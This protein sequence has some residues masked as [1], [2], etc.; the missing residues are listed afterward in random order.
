MKYPKFLSKLVFSFLIL[1]FLQTTVWAE[2][3]WVEVRSRNFHLIG[4]ASEKDIRAV[5]FKLEQFREALRLVLNQYNFNSPV[6]TTVVVFKNAEDYKPYKP[7][8]SNGAPDNFVVG[9]FQA[10]E[11]INYITL[12]TEGDPSRLYN[13]IFHEYTHF[14]LRNNLGESRIPPWYNEGMAEYYETF[15]IEDDRKVMIGAVHKDFLK[16]LSKNNLIPF[17]TFFNTD[18]Y[19]LHEQGNDG[20]GLF[21]AQ[22]WALMHY[23]KHGKDSAR[24]A[25]LDKFLKLV[26]ADKNPK[27]AFI[28]AFQ[29]DYEAMENE[30]KEYIRQ[31]SFQTTAV[32]FINKLNF[33]SEMKSSVLTDA[34]TQAYLGDLLFHSGRIAE[35]EAHLQKALKLEPELGMAQTSLGLVKLQQEDFDEAEKYLEKAIRADSGNYRVYYNYAYVLSRYGMSDFGFVSEYNTALAEKMREALKKAIELN[36][37]F[38]E[39]YNLYAFISI[40]RNEEINEAIAYL[41]KA[42]QIAP[43]NQWYLIHLSELLLRKNDFAAARSIASK[44]VQ[45]A[46]DKELKVYAQNTLG[47]IVSTE[48]AYEEIRNYKKRTPHNPLDIPLTDEELAQLRARQMLESLNDALYKPKANETRI[49]GYLTQIDC[50]P[51]GMIY[52][53]KVDN[54]ILKLRSASFETIRLMAYSQAMAGGQIGCGEMKKESFAVINYRPA[55]SVKTK[56]SGEI[57]SIE[58]VPPN[59]KFLNY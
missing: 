40:V 38:A 9:Y 21:Y 14:L 15:A 36:P 11:D 52:S 22:A 1:V 41:N 12:S 39:S 7:V 31:D 4:N 49:L 44:V 23:L 6:P 20:I 19:S 48:A 53:V 42:L 51:S 3:E 5:A 57:I 47:R 25:Q 16:V 28:E 17:D 43:G 26:M 37:N 55:E 27:D 59:F 10:S 46:G 50:E 33:D 32:S 29:A 56:T 13:I 34:R 30:L 35:A 58:F 2:N 8:K 18:N 45:T 24:S 54:K